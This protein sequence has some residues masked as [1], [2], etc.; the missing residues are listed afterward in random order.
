MGLLN[1]VAT[2][3]KNSDIERVEAATFRADLLLVI[4]TIAADIH[5]I[6]EEFAPEVVGISEE[7]GEPSAKP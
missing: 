1:D 5:A 6:R 4:A 3:R 2:I 7:H